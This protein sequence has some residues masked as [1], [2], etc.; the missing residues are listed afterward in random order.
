MLHEF[1]RRGWVV[2]AS[3]YRLAPRYP[4]PAQIEDA[5]R[6]LGL[7]QEEHR[8]VRRRSRSRRGRGRLGRRTPRVACSPSA[9]TTRRGAR[10]TWPTS[11]TGR[12]AVRSPFYGVLEM[13]GDEA[14]WRGLGRGLRRLLEHRVVQLPYD[15]N[16]DLYR[17]TLALSS[18]SALDSPPFFVVQ[19]VNDTLVEVN[20]ARAFVAKFRAIAFAPIYYVELPVHPTRLRPHGESAHV[21]DDAR[22][23]RLRRV[24]RVRPAPISRR[25]SS[26]ATRY[27]PPH[28]RCEVDG[29]W[30]D[31][32]EAARR[33][34]APS[35]SS[36]PTIPIR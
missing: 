29:E 6:A 1:V 31:A 15:G 26:R 28:C 22:G 2:V 36:R 3:N 17:A 27:R 11:P 5:T 13:T 23:D 7:D 33:R 9:R 21:G 4:W 25:R 12:C 20:V 35:S 14:H 8:D 16:E 30:L 10:R 34:S 24:G 19:G 18:A 32:R